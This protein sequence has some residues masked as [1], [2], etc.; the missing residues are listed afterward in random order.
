VEKK[1]QT[2]RFSDKELSLIKNTFSDNDDLLQMMRKVFLQ[3]GLTEAEEKIV[4]VTFKG[5]KELL[6]LMQKVF[7]PTLDPESPR[8]QLIDLWMSIDIKDKPVHE[9]RPVFE[10]RQLLITLLEQQLEEFEGNVAVDRIEISG[11]TDLFDEE[12]ES[13][14]VNLMARNSLITHV[15]QM[16]SQLEVLAGRKEESVEETLERLQQD[17]AK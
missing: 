11:L 14:Y 17:S 15:E 13:F 12:A 8:H 6:K 10:A 9:L 7:L 1:K 4:M 2:M 3:M 5:K 16:L